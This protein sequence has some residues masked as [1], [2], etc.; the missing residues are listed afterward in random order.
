MYSSLLGIFLFLFGLFMR[1]AQT[2]R[3]VISVFSLIFTIYIYLVK[4]IIYLS[5]VQCL[6]WI[7]LLVHGPIRLQCALARSEH[8]HLQG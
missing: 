1:S 2:L 6:F 8:H 4:Y 3:L 7:S 5:L